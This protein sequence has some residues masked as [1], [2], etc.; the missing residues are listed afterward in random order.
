[1]KGKRDGFRG[2]KTLSKVTPI[3]LE[4]KLKEA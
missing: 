3:C 2:C 4:K 1:M